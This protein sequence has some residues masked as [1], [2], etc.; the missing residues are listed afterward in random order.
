MCR[1]PADLIRVD[2]V[3]PRYPRSIVSLPENDY[4]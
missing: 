3:S 2:R 4:V 1:I